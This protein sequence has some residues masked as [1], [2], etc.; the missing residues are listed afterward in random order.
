MHADLKKSFV[1]IKILH[2]NRISIEYSKKLKLFSF[3]IPFE[4]KKFLTTL[5]IQ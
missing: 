4:K 3:K 5:F 2:T 1:I